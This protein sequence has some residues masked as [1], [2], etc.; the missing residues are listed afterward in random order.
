[1][2]K[3]S[4]KIN[5]LGEIKA[6]NQ[7]C[8]MKII[9]YNNT[10]DIIVEFQDKYRCKV[11][12]AYKEFEKGEIKNPYCPSVFGIGITGNKYEIRVHGNLI[13]EYVAWRSMLQ[14]CYDKRYKGKESVYKDVTCCKEWLLFENFYEWLHSQENFDKWL[15]NEKWAVDKD[16]LVKGNKIY[17][18]ETCCLVS[19]NVNSLFTKRTRNKRE[20]PTGV[21]KHGTK[22]RARCMNSFENKMKNLKDCESPE[23]AFQVYKIYKENII[24][25]VAQIEYNNGNITKR[26]YNAMINYEVEITD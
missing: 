16:I 1:M 22:F 24:K 25:Q 17:S 23:Q 2:G 20:L 10:T 12:A 5:R 3:E 14:R 18:P 19:Q 21:T 7:G 8:P 4:K 6:N 26:C 9:K 13:K 15:N 11:H